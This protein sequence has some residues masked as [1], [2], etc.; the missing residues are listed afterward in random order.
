MGL[1]VP[2]TRP[3][4]AAAFPDVPTSVIHPFTL[5]HSVYR[6][7]LVLSRILAALSRAIG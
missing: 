4:L 2:V 1:Y 6:T 3:I 7:R 5:V